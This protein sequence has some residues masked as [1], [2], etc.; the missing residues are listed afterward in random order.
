MT[1]FASHT[2][3]AGARDAR[4]TI[5]IR[6]SRRDPWR[7]LLPGLVVAGDLGA[8]L[9]AAGVAVRLRYPHQVPD[10]RI[11]GGT[12]ADDAVV[13]V[14]VAVGWVAVLAVHRVYRSSQLGSGSDELTLVLRSGI[15]FFALLAAV[16]LLAGTDVS[17]RLLV[18]VVVLLVL[19]SLLVHLAVDR[20]V[21]Y[22]HVQGWWRQRAVVFGP[23]LRVRALAELLHEDAGLGV[24]V[25]A[26]YPLWNGEG[27]PK[28]TNGARAN[29]GR[30]AAPSR[31]RLPVRDVESLRGLALDADADLVAV[32]GGI[33]PAQVRSLAWALEG[34]G[35]DLLVAPAAPGLDGQ[36]VEI[37]RMAGVPLLRVEPSRLTRSRLAV[38]AVIDRMGAAALIVLL[39]PVMLAAAACV[40][41][42]G[43]GPVMFRQTRVGQHGAP[44]ELL[45]FRT[46]VAGAEDGAGALWESNEADGLLFKLRT[47]PRVTRI[48]R[49]M[50][51]LSVDE[52]PQLWNVVRGDMSLVGPR[53]LPVPPDALRGD[54]RRRLRVK[55]GITGLWQVSGRSELSWAETVRLDIRYVDR[56]SLGLDLLIMLRTPVAVVSGRGAY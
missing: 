14:A 18:A 4:S 46:M 25:V 50:R 32:T 9:V 11:A 22:A 44:F 24:D 15:A 42:S 35:T 2:A 34:T 43:P 53:P 48:G 7:R 29:G 56:W 19:A 37:E 28:G 5:A 3:G 55:P 17:G 33:G 39:S 20:I 30:D 47:D 8:G 31:A 16:H 36:R 45:K 41:L 54:A 12:P 26:A 51:R 40:R 27:S 52:L 13:C 49:W 21:H 23:E 38:K 10:L 1:A 6:A